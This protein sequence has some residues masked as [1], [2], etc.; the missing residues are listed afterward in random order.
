M[1]ID[2]SKS[3]HK[4]LL[5]MYVSHSEGTNFRLGILTDL[6]NRGVK[7]IL[8]ACVDGLSQYP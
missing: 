1:V 3:G 7:D 4:D 6:Q 2:I 5:G 8:I